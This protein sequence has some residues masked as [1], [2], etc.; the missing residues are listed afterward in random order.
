MPVGWVEQE[1]HAALD[2][3]EQMRQGRCLIQEFQIQWL[4]LEIFVAE[5]FAQGV[6][7]HLDGQS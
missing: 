6:A 2:L 4:E 3:W 5:N 1:G 7:W